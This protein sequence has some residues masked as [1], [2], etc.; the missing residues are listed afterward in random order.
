MVLDSCEK[1]FLILF[2]GSN[3]NLLMCLMEIVFVKIGCLLLGR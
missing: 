1:L 2:G 3:N